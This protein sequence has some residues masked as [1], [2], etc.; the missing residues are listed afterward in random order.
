MPVSQQH[1]AKLETD[2]LERTAVNRRT[3]LQASVVGGIGLMTVSALTVGASLKPRFEVTPEKAPPKSGD[4][5][6]FAQGDRQGQPI[7]ASDVPENAVLL[8]FP[9]D[10][11]Q[12]LVK[13]GEVRN[14]IA[15]V[16]VK[17]E[18]LA[19]ELQ[20]RAVD[21]VIA[22]SAVCPHLG[23]TVALMLQGALYCPCHNSKFD[24]ATGA[25]VVAGP[26]PRPLAL[27]PLKLEGAHLA[28]A[29][30]FQGKVGV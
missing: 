8:A 3:V 19:S 28:V 16:R 2:A 13:G 21:G 24:P 15:L 7:R 17:P 10:P 27:L 1:D 26:A 4:L 18:S 6:V 11:A 29:A 30:G 12:K 5:L 22:Y 25:K 23:C 20:T 9:F 14:T